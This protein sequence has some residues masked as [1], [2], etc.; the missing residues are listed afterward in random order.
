M[1]C[2]RDRAFCA[3]SCANTKCSRNEAKID[4]EAADRLGLPIDYMSCKDTVLCEGYK[5]PRK[6]KVA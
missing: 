3:D 1:L 2:Y 4:H 5:A 6:K